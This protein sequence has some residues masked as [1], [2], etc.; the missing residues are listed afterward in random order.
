MADAI[1]ARIESPAEP[2]SV[3][4]SGD[5]LDAATIVQRGNHPVACSDGR[6]G[7]GCPGIDRRA[8]GRPVRHDAAGRDPGREHRPLACRQ[9]PDRPDA[10]RVRD[11]VRRG[12][13]ARLQP[14]GRRVLRGREVDPLGAG[15]ARRVRLHPAPLESARGG[16]EP[17]R[18][19]WRP[20]PRSRRSSGR[21]GSST[22]PRSW[23]RL[24]RRTWTWSRSR[25][26][27]SWSAAARRS[28]TRS[29]TSTGTA[30]TRR[31]RWPPCARPARPGRGAWSCA[32]RT[33]ARSPTSSC[34]S[35]ARPARRSPPTG[36]PGRHL[37][38]PHPQRRRARGRELH[39]RRA[40]RDPP[41]P[42]HDQRVR[43]ALRERQHG[44]R[45]REPRPQDGPRAA[46]RRRRPRSPT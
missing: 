34:R 22:S 10:R 44:Q 26:A 4:A 39:R 25:S 46:A 2:R 3:N 9:A 36:R 15:E 41:R 8:A 45:P 12:R 28:S 16:P 42:G 32:T 29:T 6:P 14:E 5:D 37:G 40:G 33:A 31:T 21:A 43:R 35:W 13:L 1:V 17:S 20:R 11:A 7:A 24:P 19:W 38:D 27:S 18:R 23:A 30:R